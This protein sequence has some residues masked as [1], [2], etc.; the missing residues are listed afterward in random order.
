MR[1]IVVECVICSTFKHLG[2][3]NKSKNISTEVFFFFF[4]PLSKEQ[5]IGAAVIEH[6]SLDSAAQQLSHHGEW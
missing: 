6:T 5:T 4:L 2:I 1:H 3:S